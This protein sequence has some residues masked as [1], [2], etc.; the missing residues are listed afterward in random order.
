MRGFNT[1]AALG[2]ALLVSVGGAGVS[3]AATVNINS[4]GTGWYQSNG[5]TTYPVN[6]SIVGWNNVT[7]ATYN[8]WT[9][10]NLSSLAGQT[11]TGATLTFRANNGTYNG[12]DASETLG[13]FGFSGN[14]NSL[15]NNQFNTA[16]YTDLGDG[17]SY[18]TT[19]VNKVNGQ[20]GAI[21]ITLSAQA[22]ADMMAAANSGD[23][24]FVIGGSL[25]TLALVHDGS[26][27]YNDAALFFGGSLADPAFLSVDVAP[28]PLPAALPMFASALAGG[29]LMA[30]RRKRKAAKAAAAA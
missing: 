29:G 27:W 14:I 13:L 19:V 22:I 21:T 9:Q 11:I 18:G 15:T 8:N 30:W 3:N 24:R 17:P 20:L 26:N 28:V 10:F 6:N 2:V 1:C 12:N 4:S 23:Q 25:L 7:G 5:L 16:N